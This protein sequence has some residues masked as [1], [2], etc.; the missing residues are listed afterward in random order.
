MKTSLFSSDV[1]FQRVSEKLIEKIK[2]NISDKKILLFLSGGSCVNIYGFL[3]KEI[4]QSDEIIQSRK[5]TSLVI[6]QVDDRFLPRKES[7]I[8]SHESKIKNREINEEDINAYK[9][10]KTG[11]WDV[12]SKRN[13]PYHVI[14]QEGSLEESA[15]QYSERI[16]RYFKEKNIFKIGIFGIGEDG[17][18]AGLMPGYQKC[19]D[20]EIPYVG[21]ENNGKFKKRITATPLFLRKLDVAYIIASGEKKKEVLA[22]L[23]NF[24]VSQSPG[25]EKNSYTDQFPAYL[26]LQVPHLEVF[27]DRKF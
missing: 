17:H 12:C 2:E 10:G 5:S 22:R 24:A 27:T 16:L 26:L 11:L 20:R 7:G 21:Y 25:E 8:K 18:T 4:E 6:F 14:P 3:A 19:W 15:I 1:F 9:I 13:V 23:R